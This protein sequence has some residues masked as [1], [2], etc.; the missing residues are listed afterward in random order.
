MTDREFVTVL[1][2]LAS[3]LDNGGIRDFLDD[4]DRADTATFWSHPDVLEADT[5]ADAW[6]PPE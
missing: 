5:A 2:K 4:V 6:Y 3:R 1:R